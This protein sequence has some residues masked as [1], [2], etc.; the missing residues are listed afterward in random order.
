MNRNLQEAHRWLAQACHD[1]DAAA[2]NACNARKILE[3]V[4]RLLPPQ[5][6]VKL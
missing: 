1:A 5:E 2:L 3:Q 6:E 4:E